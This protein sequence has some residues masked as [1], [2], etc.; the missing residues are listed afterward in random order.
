MNERGLSLTEQLVALLLGA[1]MVTALY[2]FYR[3]ELF[4]I[5]GQNA[6][7]ETL[8]DARGAM[9]IIVRDLKNAGAWARGAAP[10]E[11]G[12]ADDPDGDADGVC[13]RVYAATRRLIHIQMD[14]NG[15]GSCA[16]TEPRENVRYELTGP[17]TTCPGR[18]I[19]RRNGDCLVA[20][21]V[22]SAPGELFTYFDANGTELGDSPELS[23]IKRV[24]IAFTVQRSNPDP[25][26][27]GKVAS[28]VASS[29]EL[30]N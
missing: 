21:V 27:G 17:T 9:D 22:T 19:I 3:N 6:R 1:V 16:D 24:R 7:L 10:V 8:E 4:N 20:N 28:E 14:L 12:G 15:N 23:A 5:V 25:R 29:V 26:A 18:D 30:R 2:G 11:T 13:N